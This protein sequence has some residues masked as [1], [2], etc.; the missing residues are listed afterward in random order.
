MFSSYKRMLNVFNPENLPLMGA[1]HGK[2]NGWNHALVGL[3][4]RNCLQGETLE[5]FNLCFFL[6]QKALY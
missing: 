4:F 6:F 1:E 3:S 2:L 5:A